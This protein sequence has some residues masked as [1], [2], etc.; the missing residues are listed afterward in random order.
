MQLQEEEGGTDEQ[1]LVSS[2]ISYFIIPPQ[3]PLGVF[4][5]VHLR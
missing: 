1:R 4:L 2:S 5:C 3:A